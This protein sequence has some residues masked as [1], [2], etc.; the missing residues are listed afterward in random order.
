M[1]GSS[2][3]SIIECKQVGT[4]RVQQV[5]RMV[6]RIEGHRGEAAVFIQEA[7]S[8]I[9]IVDGVAVSGTIFFDVPDTGV[10][11]V[12]IAFGEQRIVGAI[13]GQVA[14]I[15]LV[16]EIVV[17]VG[18]RVAF[19]DIDIVDSRLVVSPRV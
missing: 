2:V 18:K 8:L 11:A 6:G 1:V 3:A 17:P 19:I 15:G 10:F 14:A 12:R 9:A 13:V 5:E 16:E 4:N 7:A